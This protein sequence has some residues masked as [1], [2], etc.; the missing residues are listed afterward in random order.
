MPRMQSFRRAATGR[1]L[2]TVLLCGFSFGSADA[3]ESPSAVNTE[4]VHRID[5]ATRRIEIREAESLL[6]E[7]PDWLTTVKSLDPTVIR[8][9]AV[10]P[11]CLRVQ[12]VADGTA[13]LQA[14][15]R[16]D[17]RYSIQVIVR[18][19]TDGR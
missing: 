10:R 17:H 9:S 2:P 8:I 13:T 6:L 4:A 15:D 5:A 16:G 7:Y 11:N 18:A 3:T 19:S 12:R 14:V 1:F